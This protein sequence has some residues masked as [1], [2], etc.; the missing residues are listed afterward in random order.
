MV[1]AHRL[2][3]AAVVLGLCCRAAMAQEKIASPVSTSIPTGNAATVNGQ[4][5]SEKA[6]Y[7]ALKRVPADKRAEARSEILSY[8]IDNLLLDQ[9][10]TRQRVSIEKKEVDTRIEQIKTEI[11]KDKKEFDKVMKELLLTEDE[12]RAQI[13]ADL[14]WEKFTTRQASDKA[15][16]ELFTNNPAMFNGSM[17]HARHIL[18]IPSSGTAQA[19]AQARTKLVDIKKQIEGMVVR[20]L[21]KLDPKLD[22]LK[23]EEARIKLL[24]DGFTELAGKESM[25]PSKAQ[26]GDLGWFPRAGRMVEPFAKAAFALKPYQLSEIVTSPFGHHLILVLEVKP[27][28]EIKFEDVKDMVKDMY[29]ER[30]RDDILEKLRPTAKIL[31]TPTPK[32]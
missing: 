25:C 29:C 30:L 19:V 27:G 23:R 10:M 4:A 28:K 12:L 3:L 17:V 1:F 14:R 31:I 24:T 20:G 21:A 7:R 13:T 9:E 15:L 5:V 18:I 6:L 22:N 16:R 11:K 32:Q 2:F 26:G 8:L